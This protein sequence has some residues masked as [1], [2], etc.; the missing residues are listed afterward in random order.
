MRHVALCKRQ[1]PGHNPRLILFVAFHE[2]E[3]PDVLGVWYFTEKIR[4]RISV[5]PQHHL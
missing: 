2:D 3:H 4:I 1:R 5:M